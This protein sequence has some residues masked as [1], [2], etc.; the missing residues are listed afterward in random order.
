MNQS[1]MRSE[2]RV[3]SE[4]IYFAAYFAPRQSAVSSEASW[5]LVRVRVVRKIYR[6]LIYDLCRELIASNF[7]SDG[8]IL[9]SHCVITFKHEWHNGKADRGDGRGSHASVWLFRRKETQL[10]VSIYIDKSL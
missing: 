5:R 8:R 7:S 3:I 1:T 2:K 4:S 9:I 6:D 10:L